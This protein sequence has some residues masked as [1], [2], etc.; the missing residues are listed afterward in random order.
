MMLKISKISLIL[1]FSL[2]LAAANLSCAENAD[3]K[4]SGKA[5][6]YDLL[7][8]IPSDTKGKIHDF[9]FEKDGKKMTFSEITKGKVVFLN[10]WGTW[11]PPCRREIPDIIEISKDLK[12]K[13]FIVI[14]IASEKVQNPLKKV[15]DFVTENNIPYMNFVAQ[16]EHVQKYGIRA[17]PTTFIIDTDGSVSELMVGMKSKDAFM[18]AINRVLK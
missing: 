6:V 14:G 18:E 7:K 16:S 5:Q 17:F 13:D 10:V 12:D 2:F 4:T 8:V 11:C 1:A 15:Q 3:S 9:T